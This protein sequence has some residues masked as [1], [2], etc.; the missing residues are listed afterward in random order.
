MKL[1]G[2]LSSLLSP[3]PLVLLILA[4]GLVLLY[5]GRPRTG[6]A[7]VAAS[8]AL[9]LLLSSQPVGRLL[10]LPLESRHEPLV[11]SERHSGIRWVVV[12]GSH[13]SDASGQPAVTRLS[14]VA[15]L[16]LAEGLRIH[17][18]LE[19]SR[20]ILSGGTVFAGAASATVMSRAA[21]SLGADPARL[22]THPG[23]RNTEE[24][25]QVLREKLGDEPFILV[26]SA[27]HMP[28]AMALARGAGLKPIPAPTVW[29][30]RGGAPEGD[31]RRWLPS[32]GGLAMSERAF[33]EYLGL[34]WVWLRGVGG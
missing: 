3:L 4:A 5:L 20:L 22:E 19:E 12:L 11:L 14:G 25:A 33:H 24:E 6:R 1:V 26:T 23:P 10:L 30:T 27:S 28:R 2:F 17:N 9:L 15:S 18:A 21:L 8:L 13:V 32:S 16:R 34:A 31:P 7:A 29:R